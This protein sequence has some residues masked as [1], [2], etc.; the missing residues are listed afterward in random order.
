MSNSNALNKAGLLHIVGRAERNALL[1]GEAQIL[2]DAIELLDDMAMTLEQIARG[3]DVEV[4]IR[5]EFDA[6]DTQSF[7]A[8]EQ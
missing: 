6:S 4:E 2:R 8:I 7:R 1:P 5:P 3:E